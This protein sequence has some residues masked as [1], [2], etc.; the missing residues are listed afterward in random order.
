MKLQVLDNIKMDELSTKLLIKLPA[1][2][3]SHAQ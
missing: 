3:A 2:W 1:Y